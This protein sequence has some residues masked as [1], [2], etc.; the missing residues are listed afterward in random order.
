[1]ELNKFRAAA[2]CVLQPEEVE[3][4]DI[5]HGRVFQGH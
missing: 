2:R 4:K 1:M 5:Y 3:M